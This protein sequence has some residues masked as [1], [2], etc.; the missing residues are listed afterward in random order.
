MRKGRGSTET[1]NTPCPE[2]FAAPL[3]MHYV[4]CFIYKT[5]QTKNT[6][7]VSTS[8][9]SITVSEFIF[10]DF[11]QSQSSTLDFVSCTICPVVKRPGRL[12]FPRTF[13]SWS[14]TQTNARVIKHIPGRLVTAAGHGKEGYISP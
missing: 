13:V 5:K 7:A 2:L 11:F 3:V 1:V 9:I 10:C 12:A 4:Q 8:F 6:T 14:D